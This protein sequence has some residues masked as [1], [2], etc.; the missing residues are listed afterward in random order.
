VAIEDV[1]PSQ[2][3]VQEALP[4]GDLEEGHG[5]AR[6][7]GV[8]VQRARVLQDPVAPGM[9]EATVWRH[10]ARDEVEGLG[11]GVD[12]GRLV[13]GE[14]G[15]GERR[16]H[17]PVP[18][19]QH[20]VVPARP[21]ARLARGAERLALQAQAILLGRAQEVERTEAVQDVGAFPV[22]GGGHVVDPLERLDLPV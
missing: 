4:A 7:V 3:L 14:A 19:C 1:E 22:P 18:V 20:L 21:G 6:H 5:G 17:Q 9:A 10:R 15:M 16:D 2:G 12:P 11:R 8:V 13:E